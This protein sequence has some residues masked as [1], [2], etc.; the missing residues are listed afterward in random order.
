MLPGNSITTVNTK[1]WL[2]ITV[3]N[4]LRESIFIMRLHHSNSK[5]RTNSLCGC[6]YLA[7]FVY[8]EHYPPMA[9]LYPGPSIGNINLHIEPTDWLSTYYHDAYLFYWELKRNLI[10]YKKLLNLAL[11]LLIKEN[12]TFPSRLV[13]DV[14]NEILLRGQSQFM[15]I[16]M[17][18]K[19][20]L[21]FLCL[22]KIA[23][24]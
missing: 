12:N 2:I 16:L 14:V 23:K 24:S 3:K 9:L 5:Y 22:H 20:F 19:C 10:I 21:C 15:N 18:Q 1:Y 17:Q 11:P 7:D 6:F 13:A 4:P 8:T